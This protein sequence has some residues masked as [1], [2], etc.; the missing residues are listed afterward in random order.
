DPNPLQFT[1]VDSLTHKPLKG[2]KNYIT[3]IDNAG[4]KTLDSATSD[5]NG[6]FTVSLDPG[7][8]ISVH[9]KYPPWYH[10]N[11]FTIREEDAEKLRNAP[12]EKRTIPLAPVIVELVFRTVDGENPT[13]LV[14]DADLVI[15]GDGLIQPVPTKSGNGEFIV[16]ATMQSK[17]SI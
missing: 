16:K 6:N 13:Q 5:A 4:K 15:T 8:K 14:P 3:I 9:A 7:S 17:I 10:D 11:D 2:V 12:Q 1:N